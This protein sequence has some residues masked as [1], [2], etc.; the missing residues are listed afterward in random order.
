[1]ATNVNNSNMTAENKANKEQQKRIKMNQFRLLTFKQELLKLSVSL[2]TGFTVGTHLTETQWLQ[3]QVNM[4]KF[5]MFR[6]GTRR[7][8]VSRT[9]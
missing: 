8:A 7:P 1:M 3:E 9:E 6:V 5:W 2:H 4:M